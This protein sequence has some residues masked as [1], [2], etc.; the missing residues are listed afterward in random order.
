MNK[1]LLLLL[2]HCC[3][4][5]LVSQPVITKIDVAN[6]NSYIEVYFDQPVYTKKKK[7]GGLRRSDFKL[8]NAKIDR[9]KSVNG[10]KD[11]KGGEKDVRI[12]LRSTRSEVIWDAIK[13]DVRKKQI[14]DNK[15]KPAIVGQSEHFFIPKLPISIYCINKTIKVSEIEGFEGGLPFEEPFQFNLIGEKAN[16][17][18]K[19]YLYMDENGNLSPIREL[20]FSGRDLIRVGDKSLMI[21]IQPIG[22][23]K[24]I[25]LGIIYQPF[26][27]VLDKFLEINNLLYTQKI[28]EAEY[29]FGRLSRSLSNGFRTFFKIEWDDYESFFD[30][31][32]KT[33]YDKLKPLG[34]TTLD[35]S[36]D[37][38]NAIKNEVVVKLRDN[39]SLWFGEFT[40]GSSDFV[41]IK[42]EGGYRVIPDFGYAYIPAFGHTGIE[43]IGL[44]YTGI[45]IYPQPVNKDLRKK[46][47]DWSFKRR[48]S[49]NLGVTVSKINS[50]EFS[51]YSDVS[52]LLGGNYKLTRVLALSMGGILLRQVD[53][54]PILD[55]DNTI[56]RPYIGLSIDVDFISTVKDISKLIK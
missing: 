52:F 53:V 17:V 41:D 56:I 2:L 5:I 54:N 13:L 34:A 15:D 32:L 18:K 38:H 48:F 3:A 28:T 7:K 25:A 9:I 8:I 55:S 36:K 19:A 31:D 16:N 35:A 44:N 4:F 12:Y 40:Y 46:C 24:N 26:G 50:D 43:N 42:T 51:T 6:D 1:L 27:D 14:F 49:F 21:R 23:R 39:E 22:P 10:S 20:T 30:S 37:S 29:K 45:S 47:L 11:L 33:I